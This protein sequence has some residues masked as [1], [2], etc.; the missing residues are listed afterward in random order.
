MK[1]PL[2]R[3]PVYDG[4]TDPVVVYNRETKEYHMLY[5]QRRAT[6][7]SIGYSNIHGT[8]IGVATSADGSDWLYRGTLKGLEFEHGDNTFWAPE[9]FYADGKYHMYLSYVQGVPTTWEYPRS[10]VYY[11]SGN[12]WDWNFEQVLALSSDKIIDACVYEIEDGLYKMWY[13][14][15][16]DQNHSYA[17]VS[18]NLRDWRVLGA[19]ICDVPHEGPNVFELGGKKWMIIDYWQGLAVYESEDFQAWT[20]KADILNVPGTRTDD[21]GFGHHADVVVQGDTGYIFYF[22]HPGE[23]PSGVAA[24]NPEYARA[25][26]SIQVARIVVRKGQLCCDRDEDFTLLLQPE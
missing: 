14:D 21:G 8:K 3:D 19:E 12:L 2:F 26:T 18:R 24:M 5:T 13:K 9:V 10:I 16:R 23:L 4:A 6:E 7:I 17:A 15:E 1:A 22:V 11:T 20:R 25:R